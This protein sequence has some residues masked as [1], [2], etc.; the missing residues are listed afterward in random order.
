[1]KDFCKSCLEL[2]K[3]KDVMEKLSNLVEEPQTS[4]RPEK[5]VNHIGKILKNGRELRMNGQIGDY[6]MDDIILDLG[7]DVNILTKHTW[8]IWES[9]D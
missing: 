9:R 4:V 2:I 1:M 8:E 7:S 6:D 3:D 5:K